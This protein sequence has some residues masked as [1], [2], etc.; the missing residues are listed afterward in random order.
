MWFFSCILLF[1]T[2]T[3]SP[4]LK[5]LLSSLDPLSV[6]QHL[7]FYDL[8]SE[9]PEGQKALAHAWAFQARKSSSKNESSSRPSIYQ[10]IISLITREPH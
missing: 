5:S 8:Y 3:A 10:A 6:A 9:T 2:L 7:A 4:Q 1:S